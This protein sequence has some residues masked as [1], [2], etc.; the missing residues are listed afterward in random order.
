MQTVPTHAESEA[1][2]SM[3]SPMRVPFIDLRR[4]NVRFP[5]A[6]AMAAVLDSGQ[7]LFGSEVDSFERE[8]AAYVG[9]AHCVGVANGLDALRLT[10]R[11]W[12]TLG[13]LA[14]GDEVLVPANSFIASALAVTECGLKL[15]FMDVDPQTF[16]VTAETA[17]ASR[18]ERTR[19]LMPVHLYGQIADIENI[20]AMCH[21]ENLLLIEDAAQAHGSK[22]S[23]RRA[24]AFG[25]A[26]GFS[27][28]PTK[29]LGALGDAGCMVT[30]D[31]A[32]ADRVRAIANYGS[33]QKY[34]HEFEGLNS[35][36]DELQA[37]ILRLKLRQLDQDNSRRREVA[38]R[39]RAGIRHPLIEVPATPADPSAHVWHIFAITC[40]QREDLVRHL[41]K[42]GVETIVHY[43]CAIHEQPAYRSIAGD[44]QMPVSERL[45]HQV[46][47]LPMSP[48]METCQVD[49]VIDAVNSWTGPVRTDLTRPR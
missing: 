27:F 42:R 10:L 20:E 48:V 39:Y 47:S 40:S 31:P 11:A 38:M 14:P 21:E 18:T 34:R 12:M 46:L 33:S 28:Y 8:F 29:N 36:M 2:E 13:A 35:R 37:A 45:S 17:A 1:T 15:R 26:A 6:E 16:N 23:D 41:E 19:A 22:A 32:L 24:G 9:A 5:I 30:D 44:V 43:P 7:Y 3:G 25:N 49:R 4:I